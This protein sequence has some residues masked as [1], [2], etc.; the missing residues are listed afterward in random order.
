MIRSILLPLDGSQ[1]TFGALPYATTLARGAGARLELVTVTADVA[2]Q[3]A[4]GAEKRFAP[5]DSTYDMQEWSPVAVAARLRSEG[6][7]WRTPR[8]ASVAGCGRSTW[9]PSSATPRP[10]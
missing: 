8:R 2:A 7:P 4:D 6:V 5:D 3:E 9:T 1:L 10:R